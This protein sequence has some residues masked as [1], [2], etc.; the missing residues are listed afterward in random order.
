MIV[1]VRMPLAWRTRDKQI[2]LTHLHG[3]VMLNDFGRIVERCGIPHLIHRIVHDRRQRV[4]DLLSYRQGPTVDL[5]RGN[6]RIGD[7]MEYRTT[8]EATGCKSRP[9]SETARAAEQIDNRKWLLGGI[10]PKMMS[11]QESPPPFRMLC[12]G[13]GRVAIC[14][15]FYV[16]TTTFVTTGRSAFDPSPSTGRSRPDALDERF[17]LVPVK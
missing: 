13:F 1:Q 7:C 4:G 17:A 8:I 6:I 16:H 15:H 11:L 3:E 10:I 2:R 12:V 9:Q 14:C 5:H